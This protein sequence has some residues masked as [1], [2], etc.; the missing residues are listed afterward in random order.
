[1]MK[2]ELSGGVVDT[3]WMEPKN[4]K[5]PRAS[6]C[7]NLFPKNGIAKDGHILCKICGDKASGFHYGVF[8]C[9]G[10]KGFFR[11]TIRH[12]LT[13]K[14]CD[15]PGQCLIM[16]ISRTRCQYCRLQKCISTG[17]SHEA[18]RLGR[19]PKKARPESSSFFMLPKTQHGGVDLDKQLKTEQMVLYIHEAYKTALRGYGNISNNPSVFETNTCPSGA[20]S[21]SDDVKRVIYTQYVPSV[22]RFITNMANQIPQFLDMSTDD[23]RALIKGCI[24]EVA[25]VHDSTH[26]NLTDALWEDTKLHFSLR[27]ESLPEMGAIGDVFERYWRILS[28]VSIMALT[29]VEVSI[30]CALLIL[31]PDREGLSAVRYL[32]N[33]Q[34]ELAMALKCQLILSHSGDKPARAFHRLVDVIT[35]LRGV[36]TLYLDAILGARVDKDTARVVDGEVTRVLEEGDAGATRREPASSGA[37][38]GAASV[39]VSVSASA[40]QMFS[41]EEEEDVEEEGESREPGLLWPGAGGK[42]GGREREVFDDEDMGDDNQNSRLSEWSEKSE[43]KSNSTCGVEDREDSN[44]STQREEAEVDRFSIGLYTSSGLNRDGLLH[45]DQGKK[46]EEDSLLTEGTD[47]S[48]DEL[49][50]GCEIKDQKINSDS[51]Q[52]E[53]HFEEAC[54]KLQRFEIKE[55]DTGHAP[56]LNGDRDKLSL[57]ESEQG[58]FFPHRDANSQERSTRAADFHATLLDGRSSSPGKATR[59]RSATFSVGCKRAQKCWRMCTPDSPLARPSSAPAAKGEP[60]VKGAPPMRSKSMSHVGAAAAKKT[61]T[62]VVRLSS[63]V[64][65]PASRSKSFSQGDRAINRS[66]LKA[67]AGWK[68]AILQEQQYDPHDPHDPHDT[69]LA[70]CPR[71]SALIMEPDVAVGQS[72]GALA[73]SGQ[74][75]ADTRV[76]PEVKADGR[77]RNKQVRNVGPSSS[78]SAGENLP[79]AGGAKPHSGLVRQLFSTRPGEI[80][81]AYMVSS[82]GLNDST[83]QGKSNFDTLNVNQPM[84]RAKMVQ[85]QQSLRTT[86]HFTQSNRPRSNTWSAVAGDGSVHP[87]PRMSWSRQPRTVAGGFHITQE[88]STTL[89]SGEAFHAPR[90]TGFSHPG[91]FKTTMTEKHSSKALHGAQSDYSVQNYPYKTLAAVGSEGSVPQDPSTLSQMLPPQGVRDLRT[92]FQAN[93]DEEMRWENQDHRFTHRRNTLPSRPIR[94]R[95][96]TVRFSPLCQEPTPHGCEK[97]GAQ[98][99]LSS[100]T[101]HTQSHSQSGPFVHSSDAGNTQ[102]SA[103]GVPYSHVHSAGT[104]HQTKTLYTLLQPHQVY[105]TRGEMDNRF[106]HS[107]VAGASPTRDLGTS[108]SS[109]LAP[110]QRSAS[111]SHGSRSDSQSHYSQ[112]RSTYT[113]SRRGLQPASQSNQAEDGVFRRQPAQNSL[114]S[115]ASSSLSSIWSLGS[116]SSSASHGPYYHPGHT[117]YPSSPD[118]GVSDVPLDMS[119]PARTH[120]AKSSSI[121]PKD[122]DTCGREATVAADKQFHTTASSAS[123]VHMDQN[124]TQKA[125]SSID[126]VSPQHLTFSSN[127]RSCSPLNRQSSPHLGQASSA[128][129][130]QSTLPINP[131]ST[132]MNKTV[133]SGQTAQDRFY[134]GD[135]RSYPVNHQFVPSPT[136]AFNLTR[137]ATSKANNSNN[138]NASADRGGNTP[139]NEHISRSPHSHQSNY[140]APPQSQSS[141]SHHSS[142]ENVGWS[143]G[144]V[145]AAS[146]VPLSASTKPSPKVYISPDQE[147]QNLS[148]R[149]KFQQFRSAPPSPS[150]QLHSSHPNFSGHSSG[151]RGRRDLERFGAYSS[152]SCNGFVGSDGSRPSDFSTIG[153]TFSTKRFTHEANFSEAAS[154]PGSN[155]DTIY[156]SD[157]LT[158]REKLRLRLNPK[159]TELRNAEEQTSGV[160]ERANPESSAVNPRLSSGQAR[161]DLQPGMGSVE[162]TWNPPVCRPR[163]QTFAGRPREDRL[164]RTN[165]ERLLRQAPSK[166]YLLQQPNDQHQQ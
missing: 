135:E 30:L 2:A 90:P 81:Q 140:N 37:V 126:L 25:F 91:N 164:S 10:C 36:S 22:V 157:S 139:L 3:A 159:A 39:S 20:T 83:Q 64:P 130:S 160:L 12:Q 86:D 96:S 100:H 166:S 120:G 156:E 110:H 138:T 49:S 136:S 107:G 109:P 106:Y 72:Y 129:I 65:S 33:L 152:H 150:G 29:D 43:A 73:Q 89:N 67:K 16:R 75:G 95:T 27:K 145:L 132:Y 98:V 35:E 48:M 111:F 162:E 6:K 14:P 158:L 60:L 117:S 11:R 52:S 77:L 97:S 7:R 76:C 119:C 69:L 57:Y 31:C 142:S 84:G 18:V 21:S 105:P 143:N 131:K 146:D 134:V 55:N 50:V 82:H 59:K 94:S 154:N 149:S 13:Y 19:C 78:G 99:S 40:S 155:S 17:M 42:R 113:S 127:T 58:K 63:L 54:A 47:I 41:E 165:I 87:H 137:H 79:R 88:Q 104:N 51:R 148:M 23:Q 85:D 121:P 115:S 15:T 133:T 62:P 34:T 92:S 44:M 144:K 151:P 38:G 161:K 32:E 26:V 125:H 101:Q 118:S 46:E 68:K 112:R 93:H 45:R 70:R 124:A 102:A 9:E 128:S 5:G 141:S 4:H 80:S 71:I 153:S 114:S 147:V 66:A 123:A 24:L 56:R 53:S 163:S 116:S 74:Y 61:K 103:S 8:S 28:K 122:T 1:M 108:W